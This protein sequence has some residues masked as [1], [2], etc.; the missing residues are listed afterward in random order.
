MKKSA[1]RAITADWARSVLPGRPP[2]A[3]KGTFGRVIV[4]AGSINYIGAAYL[5]CSGAMRVGAG[6]VT[7]ATPA[8]LLPVL[9]SKLTEVTYLPLP[10]S[11]SNTL[12]PSAARLV[13]E[14]LSNYDVLLLG[15][16]L[17]QRAEIAGFVTSILLEGA[18]VS[19]PAVIDADALNILAG[20]P[21]W[22]RKLSDNVILT[23]HPGEMAR[24]AAVSVEKVQSDRAGIAKK[25][26]LRWRKTLVL[27]GA[28]T[29]IA[30]PEGETVVNPSANP[31]LATAGT[32]DVL[33]GV[34][35]GLLAQGLSLNHA[36][37]C[38]VYLHTEAGEI[39]RER[40]GDAGMIASDLLPA[41]PLAIRKLKADSSA[42]ESGGE[43]AVSY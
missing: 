40:L 20:V 30:S 16:G 2:D 27:K 3:N 35:A 22:W 26:A 15:C 24:L 5:A 37:A 41:L 9:A 14:E 11:G 12:S 42:H 31:G 36:A 28:N 21:E 43:H 8:S 29:V 1:T 25:M 13:Q 34:I 10:E 17:G 33:A 7:L 6:L 38:G 19:P 4:V 32:G 39:V 23:P 18:K